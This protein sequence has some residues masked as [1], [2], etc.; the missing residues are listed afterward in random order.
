MNTL[1]T[2]KKERI[3]KPPKTPLQRKRERIARDLEEVEKKASAFRLKLSLDT[4]NASSIENIES[5]T[6]TTEP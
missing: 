3:R 4:L 5:P 1:E 6:T 2:P